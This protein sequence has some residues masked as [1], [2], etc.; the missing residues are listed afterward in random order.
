MWEL[1]KAEYA[2]WENLVMNFPGDNFGEM[3]Y[4]LIDTNGDPKQSLYPNLYMKLFDDDE[5][6]NAVNA[7]N[8]RFKVVVK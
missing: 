5:L 3:L 6:I 2:E 8:G 4:W 7:W 1:N